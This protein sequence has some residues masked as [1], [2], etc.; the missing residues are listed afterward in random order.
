MTWIV[1]IWAGIRVQTESFSTVSIISVQIVYV[2][3]SKDNVF[4]Y[5]KC[6]Y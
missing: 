4:V 6:K 5:V 1:I 3:A 2:L